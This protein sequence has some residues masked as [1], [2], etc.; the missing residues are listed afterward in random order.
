MISENLAV[1]TTCL[2]D[3]KNKVIII[4]DVLTDPVKL[5]E[6]AASIN[7][8]PA[9][10]L[11]QRKGYPGIRADL[12]VGS[13]EPLIIKIKEIIE[14]KYDIPPSASRISCQSSLCMMTVPES[15]LGP[16]QLIPHFDTSRQYYFAALLYLC[17]EEHGGTAFYRHNSTGYESIVPEQSEDYLDHCYKEL[18]SRKLEKRYF[19]E[20]DDYYTKIGFVP[21]RFNRLAIYKGCL[22]HSAN[23]VSDIS[24]SSDPRAGRLTANLFYSFD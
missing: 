3:E 21:A 13:I 16:Y 15:E 24:I 7:F 20:S 10:W 22:L 19:S 2:G 11:R 1:K 14:A 18:N 17:G 8:P 5:V 9:P 12:P 6:Y 23:V 4:D